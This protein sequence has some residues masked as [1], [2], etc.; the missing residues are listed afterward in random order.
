MKKSFLALALIVASATTSVAQNSKVGH[1]VMNKISDTIPSRKIVVKEYTEL[2]NMRMKDLNEMDSSFQTAYGIYMQK[3]PT[4]SEVVKQS[5]QQKLQRMQQT[6][7]QEQASFQQ[8]MEKL[9]Y[10]MIEKYMSMVKE[11]VKIVAARQK[12]NYVIDDS[13]A[14]YSTGGIDITNEV[15]KEVLILDQKNK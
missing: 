4:M 1:V 9:E 7:Q 11:A 14:L 15:I 3:E 8:D 5:E 12:L 10:D 13:S 2:S 6:L